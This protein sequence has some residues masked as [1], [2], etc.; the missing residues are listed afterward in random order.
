[1]IWIIDKFTK[2]LHCRLRL[3]RTIRTMTEIPPAQVGPEGY[4]V[5][6][7]AQVSVFRPIAEKLSSCDWWIPAERDVGLLGPGKPTL[8]ASGRS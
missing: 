4:Y 5:D 6:N 7:Q 2:P 1:M 8:G 3:L